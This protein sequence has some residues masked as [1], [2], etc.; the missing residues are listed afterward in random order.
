MHD[1]RYALGGAVRPEISLRGSLILQIDAREVR[2]LPSARS[3]VQALA[4]G[5]LAVLKRRCNMNGEEVATSTSVLHDG[6]TSISTSVLSGGV[7]CGDD[8]CASASELSG[9]EC[10]TVEVLGAVLDSVTE[11]CVG[12]E[13]LRQG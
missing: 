4:V 12:D 6:V 10:D 5:I 1:L 3:S 2:D 8:S 11:F 13:K 9:D 7:R